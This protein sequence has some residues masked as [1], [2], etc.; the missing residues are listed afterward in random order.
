MQNKRLSFFLFPSSS[1]CFRWDDSLENGEDYD[2][3]GEEKKEK[4]EGSDLEGYTGE[5]GD[6]TIEGRGI[7]NGIA[8]FFMECRPKGSNCA[9]SGDILRL[10]CLLGNTIY[11]DLLCSVYCVDCLIH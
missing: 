3:R 4:G 11:K 8:Q 5:M 1:F 7:S 6:D 2:E 10:S 9:V